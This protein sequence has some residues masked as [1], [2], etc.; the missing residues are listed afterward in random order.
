MKKSL[1]IAFLIISLIVNTGSANAQSGRNTFIRAVLTEIGSEAAREILRLMFA[2]R[3]EAR[4]AAYTDGEWLVA[5]GKNGDDF[6]YYGVNLETRDSITIRGA[7]VSANS[8][9][10]V[11][12]WYNGDYR[13][14]VAWQPSDPQVIRLQV[15]EGRD[16]ELLNRLLYRTN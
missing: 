13:Y 1:S 10:Q 16:R 4:R 15:F 3:P 14:Q 12:A 8:Q 6:N 2:P 9:R 7:I 11:Y 5:I